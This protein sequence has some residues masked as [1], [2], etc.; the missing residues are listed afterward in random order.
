MGPA[1]PCPD[2]A[3]PTFEPQTSKQGDVST[4]HAITG[5]CP[6]SAATVAARL[7]ADPALMQEVR[8]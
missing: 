2:V 4:V 6:L 8:L 5:G 3:T 1:Y 7:T